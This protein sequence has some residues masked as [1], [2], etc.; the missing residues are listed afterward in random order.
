MEDRRAPFEDDDINVEGITAGIAASM[1]LEDPTACRKIC[2][3]LPSLVE[4][5][6]TNRESRIKR[7]GD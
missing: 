7:T 4:R 1:P 2:E 6:L 3:F 5:M